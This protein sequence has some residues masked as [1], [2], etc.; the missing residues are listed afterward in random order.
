MRHLS[1]SKANYP[2]EARKSA[3][4]EVSFNR[5]LDRGPL[6]SVVIPAT[7][8]ARNLR[9]VLP[10]IP[11]WVH[12]VVL[13]DKQSTDNTVQIARELRP[14]IRF[15]VQEGRG[16]ANALRTGFAAATGDIVVMLDADDSTDPGE[17]PAFVGV[18][19][20]DADIGKESRFWHGSGP[21]DMPFYDSDENPS[22]SSFLARRDA[23]TALIAHHLYPFYE[24]FNKGF[25]GYSGFLANRLL[26]AIT[27]L[28]HTQYLYS[29]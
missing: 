27:N 17:I 22:M 20:S 21:K 3:E 2:I 28:S 1:G 12:E 10:Y 14:D 4:N 24:F 29:C 5:A 9:Y 26:V 16:K 15:V 25:K 23:L 19:L 18:L 13:I 6:V 7:G 8:P 11:E